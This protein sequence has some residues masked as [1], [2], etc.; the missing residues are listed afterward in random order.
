ML[1][2]C[3]LHGLMLSSYFWLN[4]PSF[5]KHPGQGLL[6]IRYPAYCL[7]NKEQKTPNFRAV[8]QSWKITAARNS[9]TAEPDGCIGQLW[10]L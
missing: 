4:Q 10:S 7:A 1:M 2:A 8:I 9:S 6:Q 5:S 3:M